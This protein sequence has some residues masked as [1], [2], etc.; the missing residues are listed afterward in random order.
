MICLLQGRWKNVKF[1]IISIFILFDATYVSF[2][3]IFIF[4]ESYLIL[5]C[6]IRKYELFFQIF[7][8]PSKKVKY[9][10][11]YVLIL[12]QISIVHFRTYNK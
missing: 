9:F 10:K 2:L 3:G 7:L 5:S 12:K 6:L 4:T 11:D 8:K 1:A